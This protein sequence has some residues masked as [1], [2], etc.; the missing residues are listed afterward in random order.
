MSNNLIFL[1]GYI[2]KFEFFWLK[3][4]YTKKRDFTEVSKKLE[5]I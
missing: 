1:L 2:Y 3:Y 5:Q 4:I